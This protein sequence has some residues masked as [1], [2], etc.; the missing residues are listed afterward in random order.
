M[1]ASD[2]QEWFDSWPTLCYCMYQVVDN[3]PQID[4]LHCL[5][6]NMFLVGALATATQAAL[7]AGIDMGMELVAEQ[8]RQDAMR[9]AMGAR[10][11]TQQSIIAPSRQLILPGILGP[12]GK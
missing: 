1:S 3:E 4:T 7:Q 2:M 11:K 6:V 9:Q 10:G 5:G 8:M 12:R